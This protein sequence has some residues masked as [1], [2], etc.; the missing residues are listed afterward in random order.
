MVRLKTYMG[1]Y[2]ALGTARKIIAFSHSYKSMHKDKYFEF[3][4][5]AISY[6]TAQKN[7][8]QNLQQ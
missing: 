5:T 8:P 3:A 2:Y 1:G 4:R 6:Y 7:L